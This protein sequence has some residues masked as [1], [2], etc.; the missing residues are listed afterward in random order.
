MAVYTKSATWS[1]VLFAPEEQSIICLL[2]VNLVVTV[3]KCSR[4]VSMTTL[5]I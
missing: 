2:F 1:S 3:T 5:R 4:Y